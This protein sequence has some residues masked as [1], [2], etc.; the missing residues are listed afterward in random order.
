MPNLKK[1]GGGVRGTGDK[2]YKGHC[3][4]QNYIW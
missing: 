4:K 2:K 1:E 3:E